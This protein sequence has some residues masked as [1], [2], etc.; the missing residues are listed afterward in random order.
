MEDIERA[1]KRLQRRA[2]ESAALAN[3]TRLPKPELGAH[4]VG[5]LPDRVI[6]LRRDAGKEV[7]D[8]LHV[9]V[10]VDRDID[11]RIARPLGKPLAVVE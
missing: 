9:G 2:L 10:D 7:E 1:I 4:P 6:G 11:S 3:P 5:E 8:V